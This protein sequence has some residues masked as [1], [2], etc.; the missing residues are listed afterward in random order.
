MSVSAQLSGWSRPGSGDVVR[1]GRCRRRHR[2]RQRIRGQQPE[3]VGDRM[4]LVLRRHR[5]RG[6]GAEQLSHAADVDDDVVAD[7]DRPVLQQRDEVE[8]DRRRLGLV[9]RIEQ[10]QHLAA[11]REVAL[12]HVDLRRGRSRS[13]VR[14]RPA[15]SRRPAPPSAARARACRPSKLSR[16]QRVGDRRCSPSRSEPSSVL[17]AVAL[18][19]VD[20]V[21]LALDDLDQ[22]VG[23]LLLAVGVTR[24]VRPCTR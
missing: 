20:L 17:L 7:L 23:E 8:S 14:R 19:E 9:R 3:V 11:P 24:S 18:D 4:R 16:L 21:L 2:P 5:H 12:E 1:A 6:A 22:P 13:S 10:Q 15:P